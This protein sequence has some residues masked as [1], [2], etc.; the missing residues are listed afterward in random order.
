MVGK[1]EGEYMKS[2]TY[3]VLLLIVFF[4]PVSLRAQ[5]SKPVYVSLPGP[6]NV[7]HLAYIVAKEKKFYDEMA[8]P[9]STSSCCA[10]TR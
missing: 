4:L 5:I 1:S 7:Q 6:G 3:A 9:P 10:A 8:W 2:L